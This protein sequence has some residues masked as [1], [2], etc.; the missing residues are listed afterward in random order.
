MIEIMPN[1]ANSRYPE[2]V[3]PVLNLNAPAL[4]VYIRGR[5]GRVAVCILGPYQ[6]CRCVDSWL[7]RYWSGRLNRTKGDIE[8]DEG[9]VKKTKEEHFKYKLNGKTTTNNK[10]INSNSNGKDFDY[11]NG[12]EHSKG[13]R[14]KN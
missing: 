1:N 14:E 4:I 2:L 9:G 6:H 10:I 13:N 3:S 7:G 11:S 5:V 8:V 12:A